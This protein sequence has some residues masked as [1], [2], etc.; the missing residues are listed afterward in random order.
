MPVE[1]AASA[2]NTAFAAALASFRKIEF[3]AFRE[4][5]TRLACALE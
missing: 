5:G 3:N 4:A 2:A 1:V